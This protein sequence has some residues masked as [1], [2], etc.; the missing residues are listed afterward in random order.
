MVDSIRPAYTRKNIL[1][2]F[3]WFH[4]LTTPEIAKIE[5]K[6]FLDDFLSV[7][8]KIYIRENVKYQRRSSTCKPTFIFCVRPV[9]I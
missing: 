7:K 2:I 9:F 5:K 1:E 3:A 6:T 4:I 8:H